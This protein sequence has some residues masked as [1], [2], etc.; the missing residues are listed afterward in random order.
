MIPS[1]SAAAPK[2]FWGPL[3][4][5]ILAALVGVGMLLTGHAHRVFVPDLKVDGAAAQLLGII[6]LVISGICLTAAYRRRPG[7]RDHR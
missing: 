5:G 6:H 3:I 1:S 7:R 2:S 4:V